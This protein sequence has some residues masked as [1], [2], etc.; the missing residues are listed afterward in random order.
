FP[1]TDPTNTMVYVGNLDPVIMEDELRQLFKCFGKGISVCVV[2]SQ[3]SF[4]C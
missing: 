4:R 2:Y 3:V 1:C